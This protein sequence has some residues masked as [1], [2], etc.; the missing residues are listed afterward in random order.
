MLLPFGL[1][2]NRNPQ[3]SLRLFCILAWLF[4]MKPLQTITILIYLLLPGL[5]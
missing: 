4:Y 5:H 2:I 3:S 1:P